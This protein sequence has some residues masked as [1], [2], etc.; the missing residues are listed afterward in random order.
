MSRTTARELTLKLTFEL[1]FQEEDAKVLYERYLETCDDASE[2]T[3][4]DEEY[5]VGVLSG[6]QQNSKEIDEKIKAHLKDWNLERISKIDLAILRLSIY[7]ILYRED[8]PYKVAINEVVELSKSFGD[9]S[10]P[11]FVNGVLAEIVKE[12]E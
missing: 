5:I 6:I 9:D 12:L 7:E 8:I 4:E 3:T 2:I 1:S 10:S 11:S